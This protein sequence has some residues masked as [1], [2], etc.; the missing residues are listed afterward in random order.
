[1]RD[2]DKKKI[3]IWTYKKWSKDISEEE[4]EY[5]DWLGSKLVQ[6]WFWNLATTETV[7]NIFT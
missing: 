4:Y 1:M 5:N 3:S 7:Q 2:R 6:F